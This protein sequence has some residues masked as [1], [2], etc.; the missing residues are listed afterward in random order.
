MTRTT[1]E[2]F[3]KS[4]ISNMSTQTKTKKR[5]KIKKKMSRESAK[6]GAKEGSV[7]RMVH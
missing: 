3:S 1:P 2:S 5:I 4:L 7:T 6:I